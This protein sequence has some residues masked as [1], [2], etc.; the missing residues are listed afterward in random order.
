VSIHLYQSLSEDS[1]GLS[2]CD[3]SLKAGMQADL[4]HWD[5]RPT[6]FF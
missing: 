6:E 4:K 2:A 1:P 5:E 3:S